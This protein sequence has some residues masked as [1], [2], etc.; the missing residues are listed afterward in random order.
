VNLYATWGKVEG[1]NVH[2]DDHDV[3]VVQIAGSKRWQVFAPTR[4]W[5][6]ERDA[7][8]A[9]PPDTP[10]SAEPLLGPGDVLYLPHGWWHV[11]NAEDSPSL[12]LTIGVRPPS[13]IDLLDHLVDLLRQHEPVRRRLPRFETD[14]S[15]EDYVAAI[16][17][18]VEKT[19]SA[20]T[21]H[22]YL[23]YVDGQKPTRLAVSLPY[24]AEDA[25][26]LSVPADTTLAFVAPTAVIEEFPDR[27]VLR[28]AGRSWTFRPTT[29]APMLRHLA[30]GDAFTIGELS[31]VPAS[32]GLTGAQ[33]A[34]LVGEL[35]RAGLV[36]VV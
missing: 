36:G 12:H 9:P 11:A 13:G 7:E 15:A 31:R 26:G 21:L 30:D 17:A 14:G 23:R 6:T 25:G 3:F 10:P 32:S 8:P 33:I 27:T 19:L 18:L 16:A 24:S 22:D 1:F 35:I 20:Q 2:W 34:V 29:V 5:P 28:A 4:P